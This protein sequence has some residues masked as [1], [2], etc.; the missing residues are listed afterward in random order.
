M[1]PESIP[2]GALT[3][4]N[5]AFIE[6][7]ETFSLVDI[8]GDIVARVSRLKMTYPGLRVNVAIG[9][10]DFND[11]PTSNYFSNMASSYDNR[12]AFINSVISYLQK[13]GLDGIDIGAHN[14]RD[15]PEY[16][17]ELTIYRYQTGSTQQLLTAEVF[18][19]IR[20]IMLYFWVRFRKRSRRRIPA[21][22]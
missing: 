5:L 16:R 22:R 21:G 2:A 20:R 17:Y 11:P 10:W 9:G 6:F 15:L 4:I 19:Q 13:Y 14:P 7:D 3:H 18:P 8:Q 1:Q 12:Q